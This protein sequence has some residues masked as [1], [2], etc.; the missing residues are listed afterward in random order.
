MNNTFTVSVVNFVLCL[1]KKKKNML[2]FNLYYEKLIFL[3]FA[4]AKVWIN[5]KIRRNFKVQLI[6]IPIPVSLFWIMVYRLRVS[7]LF[8]FGLFSVLLHL[9]SQQLLLHIIQQFLN[10]SSLQIQIKIFFS[11][12]L[13]T[14]H[15]IH[16]I[17]YRFIYKSNRNGKIAR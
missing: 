7:F 15:Y 3:A 17:Q 5:V 10:L 13:H 12:A 2:Q 4:V 11:E 9:K 6:I 16:C 1:Q 14:G 8:F